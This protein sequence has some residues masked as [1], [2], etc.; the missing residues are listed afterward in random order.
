MPGGHGWFSTPSTGSNRVGLKNRIGHALCYACLVKLCD[1]GPGQELSPGE[2]DPAPML[3]HCS[4]GGDGGP[5]RPVWRWWAA[6]L[7]PLHRYCLEPVSTHLVAPGYQLCSGMVTMFSKADGPR[8][9]QEYAPGHPCSTQGRQVI[10]SGNAAS[11][12]LL[13]MLRF[14]LHTQTLPGGHEQGMGCFQIWMNGGPLGV[15][16]KKCSTYV[17]QVWPSLLLVQYISMS[18]KAKPRIP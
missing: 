5:R 2:A 12:L 18:V 8:R 16:F 14:C 15:Q 17:S 9:R 13:L 10:R 3:R 7:L 11:E 6:L 4:A 1:A